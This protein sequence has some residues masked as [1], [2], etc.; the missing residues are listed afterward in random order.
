MIRLMILSFRSLLIE[1]QLI[2][3][4]GNERGIYEHFIM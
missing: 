4:A 2:L 1:E 3:S